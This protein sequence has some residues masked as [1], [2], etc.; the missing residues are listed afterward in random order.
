MKMSTESSLHSHEYPTVLLSHQP[1]TGSTKHATSQKHC[2]TREIMAKH[3]QL[4]LLY[5]S[6]ELLYTFDI[7][8]ILSSELN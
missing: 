3:D 8:C 4:S 1:A 5:I 2:L 6:L 7:N